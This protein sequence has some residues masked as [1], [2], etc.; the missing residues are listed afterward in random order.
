[1]HATGTLAGWIAIEGARDIKIYQ[2]DNAS[3]SAGAIATVPLR[4]GRHHLAREDAA[5]IAAAPALLA[6]CIELAECAEYWSEYDVPIGIVDRLR[7]TIGK[8][9]K[10][11]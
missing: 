2:R 9:N 5:L 1:M 4:D 6:I 11:S 10:P 7:D 8:A 3:K